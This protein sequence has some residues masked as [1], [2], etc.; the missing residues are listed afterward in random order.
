MKG[1]ALGAQIDIIVVAPK[2]VQ[3]YSKDLQYAPKAR[4]KS[5]NPAYVIFPNKYGRQQYDLPAEA[6]MAAT[7]FM[8]Y[9]GTV[10][11]FAAYRKSEVD[12]SAAPSVSS[13][14]TAGLKI[15]HPCSVGFTGKCQCSQ[16]GPLEPNNKGCSKKAGLQ[17]ISVAAAQSR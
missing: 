11:Y 12:G 9:D 3:L 5:D 10:H 1:L 16:Q 14:E 8:L 13:A 2:Q 17:A 6:F 4:S 15:L 7:R